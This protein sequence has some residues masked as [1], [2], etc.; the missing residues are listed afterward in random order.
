MEIAKSEVRRAG[1]QMRHF[2]EEY[3]KESALREF[4]RGRRQ[5]SFIKNEAIL[6]EGEAVGTTDEIVLDNRVKR[7]GSTNHVAAK[8]DGDS[9]GESE[10]DPRP[11]SHKNNSSGS[12]KSDYGLLPREGFVRLP[13]ILE[14]LPISRSSWWAGVKSGRYPAGIKLSA[15]TTVWTVEEIWTVIN[16][17]GRA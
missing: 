3:R 6:I 12:R 10:P 2:V 9:D 5:P 4:V 1:E 11:S 8:D 14:V 17:A 7:E 16:R 15:R 13:K